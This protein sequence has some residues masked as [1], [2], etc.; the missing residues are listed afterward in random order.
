MYSNMRFTS[1]GGLLV[2]SAFQT[3]VMCLL[4]G[5]IYKVCTQVER[6]TINMYF[7]YYVCC[8]G[9]YNKVHLHVHVYFSSLGMKSADYCPHDIYFV[10]ILYEVTLP[11]KLY[12][13]TFC[14]Q[15]IHA[16]VFLVCCLHF[17]SAEKGCTRSSQGIT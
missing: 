14:G 15:L 13:Y 3:H 8:D 2:V 9:T 12:L 16:S 7:V 11:S 17:K 1:T 6:K 5:Q 4:L 10:H